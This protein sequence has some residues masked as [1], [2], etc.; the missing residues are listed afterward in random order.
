MVAVGCLR[1]DIATF[2][3]LRHVC[4]LLKT[5]RKPG[6]KP[7]SKQVFSKIDLMEFVNKLIIDFGD[8]NRLFY[9][10][11]GISL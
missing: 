11:R 4:D 2:E 8:D 7:G 10:H 6:R 3:E 1:M 5:C 9:V